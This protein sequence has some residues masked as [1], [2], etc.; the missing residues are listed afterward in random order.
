MSWLV[1]S[2]FT[3]GTMFLLPQT[4]AE[5]GKIDAWFSQIGGIFYALIVAYFFYCLSR[6]FPGKNLFQISFLVGGKYFGALFN[7]FFLMHI[8]FILIRDT[9]IIIDLMKSY[10]LILTPT[11][12]QLLLLIAVLVYFGRMNVEVTARVNEVYFPIFLITVGLLFFT[13]ADEIAFERLQPILGEGFASVWIPNF[14]NL[15]WYGD[16][17]VIG[18]FLHTM[19]ES[20]LLHAALRHGI[21]LSG[22]ISTFFVWLS[23][24]VLGATFVARSVYPVYTTL[25]HIKLTEFLDRVDLALLGIWLPVYFIKLIIVFTA[26][27]IVISS[28]TNSTEYAMYSVHAGAFIIF[29]TYFGFENVIG[30][31]YFANYSTTVVALAYQPLIFLIVFILSRKYPH[32]EQNNHGRRESG[33]N[34][35]NANHGQ[36]QKGIIQAL[37]IIPAQTW[38]NTTYLSVVGCVAFL[39]VG[40]WFGQDEVIIGIIAGS[41]YAILLALAMVVSFLDMWKQNKTKLNQ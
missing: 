38:R 17:I 36:K 25:Q 31:T 8:W 14:L 37:E 4:L 28:F 5:Y 11:E 13:L 24:I 22:V 10:I 33:N 39:F 2:L 41:A 18:A 20:K 32:A 15:G 16:I 7:I 3:T 21:V 6:K 9:R 40:A 1:A 35:S 26:F 29:T 30:V 19:Y 34:Q 12:V 23:T 27:L